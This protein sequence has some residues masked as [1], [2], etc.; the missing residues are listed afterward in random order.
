MKMPLFY[1][2]QKS[3][4]SSLMFEER[5]VNGAAPL[6]RAGGGRGYL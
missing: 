2:A 3:H 4:E 1:F 5:V 6:A